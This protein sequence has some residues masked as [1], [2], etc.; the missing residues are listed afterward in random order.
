VLSTLYFGWHY[1]ADDVAGAAIAFISVWLSGLATGQ[2][3]ERHGKGSHPTTSTA[4]LPVGHDDDEP[5]GEDGRRR[6]AAAPEPGQ[7]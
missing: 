1:I 6:T 5:T 4:R 2:R 7:G 3:F